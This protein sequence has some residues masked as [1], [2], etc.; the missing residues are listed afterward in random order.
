M[1]GEGVFLAPGCKVIGDVKIGSQSSVWFNC[2]VRGDVHTISIGARCN[3]QDGVIMHG[4]YKKWG[5][6]LEDDV[7]IGHGAILHG[8]HI[9]RGSLIGMGSTI[10]DGARIGANCLVAAGTLVTEGTEIQSG[11]VAM[12]RPAKQTRLLTEGEK[13]LLKNTTKN[14]QMYKNWYEEKKS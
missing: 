6:V 4:M 13:D 10:M 3:I 14:Y 5:V 1:L 12:G 8:C 9:G 2:T 11:Y 7:S